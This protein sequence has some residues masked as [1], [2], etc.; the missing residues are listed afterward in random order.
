[1]IG[2]KN[3]YEAMKP[4]LRSYVALLRERTVKLHAPPLSYA[5]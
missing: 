1:M 3:A 2:Y 5:V 4:S